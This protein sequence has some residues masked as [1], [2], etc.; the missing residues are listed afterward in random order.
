MSIHRHAP[1]R[2]K[3][4]TSIIEALRGVGAVCTLL[5]GNGIPDVMCLWRGVITLL[6]IKS[7]KGRLT[8]AQIE[9]HAQALNVGIKI[10]VVHTPLEALTAIGA[11]D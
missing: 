9:Y 10:H 5:S 2:D 8:P 4:E 6:E 7:D 11:I 3:N 1:K